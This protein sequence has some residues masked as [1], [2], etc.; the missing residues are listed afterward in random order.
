VS[1][2]ILKNTEHGMGPP[3][4]RDMGREKLFSLKI[5]LSKIQ[6]S[7]NLNCDVIL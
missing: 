6:K 7:Y 1:R 4:T 2:P 5:N 3:K